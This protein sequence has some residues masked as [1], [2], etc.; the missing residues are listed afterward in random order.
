MS[1]AELC[2]QAHYSDNKSARGL[3]YIQS[4]DMSQELVK[5]FADLGLAQYVDAF[6]D[7]G[8]DA[9]DTILDIQESDL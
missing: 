6:I 2:Q 3:T 5:I 4:G 8:F 1:A 9:W 7:Q